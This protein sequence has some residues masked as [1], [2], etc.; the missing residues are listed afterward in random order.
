MTLILTSYRQRM[1]AGFSCVPS[2]KHML[3]NQHR[4]QLYEINFQDDSV[5]SS[6]FTRFTIKTW[7]P[8][9]IAKFVRWQRR[10]DY[11]LLPAPL[12]PVLLLPLLDLPEDFEEK[13]LVMNSETSGNSWL[14]F[15]MFIDCSISCRKRKHQIW[16]AALLDLPNPFVCVNTNWALPR[17]S[18]S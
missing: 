4:Q 2:T 6:R 17:Q 11:L 8:P 14:E 10:L 9:G 13:S 12:L 7:M 1:K 3:R 16:E 5:Y 18:Y 15:N